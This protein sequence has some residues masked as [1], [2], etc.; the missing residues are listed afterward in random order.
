MSTIISS[1]NNDLFLLFYLVPT[2]PLS[3]LQLFPN[4]LLDFDSISFSYAMYFTINFMIIHLKF[5]KNE[6]DSMIFCLII[7]SLLFT[8]SFLF[9][10]SLLLILSLLYILFIDYCLETLINLTNVSFNGSE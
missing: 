4:C 5:L 6:N 2:F 10:D 3:T 1:F 8:D 7:D 9:T